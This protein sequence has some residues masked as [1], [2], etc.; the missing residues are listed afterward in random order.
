MLYKS[1]FKNQISISK[2]KSQMSIS[3]KKKQIQRF[4]HLL[5]QIKNLIQKSN[6]NFKSQKSNSTFCKSTPINQKYNSKVKCQF[7]KSKIKFNV[8]YIHSN[9]SKI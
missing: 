1:F 2:V 6:V 8:L 5:Q 4:V 3:K 9:K 7:Q